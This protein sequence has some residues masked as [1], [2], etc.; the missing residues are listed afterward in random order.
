VLNFVL[1][2]LPNTPKMGYQEA[3]KHIEIQQGNKPGFFYE[4]K[5]RMFESCRA[6]QV[7]YLP[8]VTSTVTGF[9]LFGFEPRDHSVKKTQKST[10]LTFS[11]R[12][13]KHCKKWAY[14]HS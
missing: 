4:P 9:V 10:N 5:G 2:T 8:N 11:P 1:N 14:C 7:L 6:H 3:A 13:G 12:S